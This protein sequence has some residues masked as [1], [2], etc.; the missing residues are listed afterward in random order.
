MNEGK[1]YKLIGDHGKAALSKQLNL[2][3]VNRR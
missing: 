2:R 3:K 1:I